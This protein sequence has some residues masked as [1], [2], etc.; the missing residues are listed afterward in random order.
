[1]GRE[2]R[3]EIVIN[4]SL[5]VR[6]PIASTV[7]QAIETFLRAP[8]LDCLVVV[9]DSVDAWIV[10]HAQPSTRRSEDVLAFI[11]RRRRASIT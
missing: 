2:V 3:L 8:N 6:T 9:D 11:D 5:N 7:E 10:A 4:T 1:M